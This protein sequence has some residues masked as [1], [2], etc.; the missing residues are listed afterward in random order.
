MKNDNLREFYIKK[1]IQNKKDIL[2]TKGKEI[3]LS[4]ENTLINKLW[5]N[6]IT[7]IYISYKNK[8]II[9][10]ISYKKLI[11]CAEIQLYNYLK[12]KLQNNLN[13]EDWEIDH[14][15]AIANFDLNNESQQYECFHYTNLQPLLMF[16]NR[17]KGVK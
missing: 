8:N 1:Y 9:R 2:K 4:K 10:T 3:R 5:E 6:L 11:G 14:I 7:R 12:D 13:M 17:S 16:E 15:K